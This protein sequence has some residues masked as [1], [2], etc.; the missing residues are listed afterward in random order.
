MNLAERFAEIDIATVRAALQEE[1]IASR[2]HPKGMA[3]ILRMEDFPRKIDRCILRK[4][5]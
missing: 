4:S 3:K 2:K 5:G 1:D